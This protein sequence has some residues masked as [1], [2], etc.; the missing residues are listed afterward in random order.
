MMLAQQSRG[1]M[2][3]TNDLAVLENVLV[4]G[5]LKTL[6]AN[7][8]VEYYK[9]VC[10]SNK[11]NPF[12]KP[13][14]YISL[15]GKVTLYANKDCAAQLRRVHDISIKITDRV[16]TND[17]YV[18]TAFAST[19]DGRIDESIGAVNI[20]GLRGEQLA[21]AF[22][23]A[24][25]KAKRRVTLSIGGLGF[26]DESEI[27]S[28]RGAKRVNVNFET[29]EIIEGELLEPEHKESKIKHIE[30]SSNT[31]KL[32]ETI[33]HDQA[34][35]LIKLIKDNPVG[36]D[37]NRIKA[38]YGIDNLLKLTPEQYTQ[39]IDVINLK[40]EKRKKANERSE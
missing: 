11:L 30:Q 9:M 14:D 24:E 1:E 4:N 35:S 7:Q 8:R 13:F 37:E 23:K 2:K 25:T 5:D 27:D 40:T 18:V 39:T 10:E 16:V 31:K 29:G 26:V 22:M 17:V 3:M 20:A 34:M 32:I 36:V 19:K 6:P 38:K 21:N 15:Q 28:I 33:T 12:T